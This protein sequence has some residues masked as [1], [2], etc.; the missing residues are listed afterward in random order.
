L[1]QILIH[2]INPQSFN[3]TM[4]TQVPW[5]LLLSVAL[6]LITTSAGTA[7]LAGRRAVS[8]DAVLAVREDW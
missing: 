1:S 4:T 6:A 7:V 5:G 3:W 2:V 8:G